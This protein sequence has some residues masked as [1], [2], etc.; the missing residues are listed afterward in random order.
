MRVSV[1]SNIELLGVAWGQGVPFQ[2]VMLFTWH[3]IC[4]QEPHLMFT[5]CCALY[6]HLLLKGSAV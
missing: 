6:M 4:S 2:I 3:R 5:L 1:V